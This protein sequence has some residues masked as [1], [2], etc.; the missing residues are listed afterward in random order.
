MERLFGKTI[1]AGVVFGRT[2][3]YIDDRTIT[4]FYRCILLPK[5][6]F[7]TSKGTHYQ[8]H[9]EPSSTCLSA[10]SSSSIPALIEKVL[11][12]PLHCK[13]SHIDVEDTT[14][15]HGGERVLL[16][17][18]PPGSIVL[19]SVP[20][21]VMGTGVPSTHGASIYIANVYVAN[22]DEESPSILP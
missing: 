7:Y 8:L 4:V 19:P 17:P 11:L 13:R 2:S 22:G 21:V 14:V 18:K 10:S 15:E 9:R 6:I 20:T 3:E 1:R 16:F 5:C 12:C